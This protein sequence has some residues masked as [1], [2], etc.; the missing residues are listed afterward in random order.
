MVSQSPT[1]EL[2]IATAYLNTAE[3]SFNQAAMCLE[4]VQNHQAAYEKLLTDFQ[5]TLV[6]LQSQFSNLEQRLRA[7]T[8]SHQNDQQDL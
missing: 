6:H 7:I 8:L 2:K 5:A 3:E 1:K 4:G